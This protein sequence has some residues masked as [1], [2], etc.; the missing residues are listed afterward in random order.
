[1]KRYGKAWERKR[2]A[3]L[4][5]DKYRSQLSSRY[6][7]IVAANTVHHIL[8][9]EFFPEYMWT[10]WNLISVTSQEHNG[11]HDRDTHG[12]TDEGVKLARR[13]ALAHGL[14][15]EEVMTRLDAGRMERCHGD[16]EEG[17]G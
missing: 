8:P 15:L 16:E 3:I 5:R 11:L 17:E 1:M 10:D 9:V 14:D 7:R 12:L 6:G 2:A 4:R 13:T